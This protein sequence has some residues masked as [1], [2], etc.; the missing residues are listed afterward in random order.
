[1]STKKVDTANVTNE[2]AT[3]ENPIKG[4]PKSL[5]EKY[6]NKSKAIR[7]LAK[8]GHSR[9]EIAKALDIRYQHVRNVLV[10]VTK[11]TA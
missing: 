7:A 6:G 11:E 4:T 5:I 10:T 2:N 8:E 3:N 1:M 9:S